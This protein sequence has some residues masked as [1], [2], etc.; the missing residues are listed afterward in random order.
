MN[1]ILFEEMHQ[2]ETH[3]L[4]WKMEIVWVKVPNKPQF[5]RKHCDEKYLKRKNNKT[6]GDFDL[7]S[8]PIIY[9][10]LLTH[11]SLQK[12]FK[13]QFS[14]RRSANSNTLVSASPLS[15]FLSQ[16]ATK[17]LRFKSAAIHHQQNASI[18]L[19]T[20]RLSALYSIEEDKPPPETTKFR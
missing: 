11:I 13:S 8:I 5:F 20:H 18:G 19:P 6:Q 1:D 17:H 10:F 3:S 12:T 14:V 16:M 2:L 4:Y 15:P 9:F 7:I